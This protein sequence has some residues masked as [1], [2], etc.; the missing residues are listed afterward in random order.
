MSQYLFL[1]S[2]GPVQSFIAAARKTEDLW[3]GSYLLS[4]LAEKA[5]DEA[6][7]IPF[8]KVE[9]IYPFINTEVNKED[10]LLKQKEG[11]M[12]IA[13]LPN[14]ILLWAEVVNEEEILKFGGLLEKRVREEVKK[15]GKE[16]VEEVFK[17]HISQS[18][19]DQA[20]NQLNE[21]L[22]VYWTYL[23]LSSDYNQTRKELEKRL[24]AMKN[25]KQ[26][27][28]SEQNGLIC[29]VCGS[30]EAL[31]DG[32]I[33]EN[34]G[35]KIMR[36]KIRATWAKRA[37]EYA[38][39]SASDER[40]RIRDDERLCAVCLAK[41]YARTYFGKIRLGDKKEIPPFPS[42]TE[43]TDKKI[44]E[45]FK[46][47]A[48][49]MMD[50]DDM[51]KWISGDIY[52]EGG[53][54]ITLKYHQ[55]ISE[56]LT[57][58][59]QIYVPKYIYDGKG[60]LIYA[61]GDD[62][63]AFARLTHLYELMGSLR[64]AFQDPQKGLDEKAT[65]SMGVVIAHEKIPLQFVLNQL[66]ELEKSAKS[67]QGKNQVKKKNAFALGLYTKS[68]E[69]REVVL[70][71]SSNSEEIFRYSNKTSIPRILRN[72]QNIMVNS[73]SSTFLYHFAE[74]FLP[75][76]GSEKKNNKK[77]SHIADEAIKAELSR[78]LYR[79]R[80]EGGKPFDLEDTVN[81]LWTLYD[82][83]PSLLQFIHLLQILRFLA[84][85]QRKREEKGVRMNESAVKTG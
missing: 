61:G 33:D 13:S 8:A 2:I 17:N 70:P 76:V 64:E 74:A 83:S 71:W 51:G 3:S 10:V 73:L 46:Y 28:L 41:R 18:M 7:M 12:E 59:S 1:M 6:L 5:I 11:K 63:L 44:H 35:I 55:Q 53:K 23:L 16:A 80:K 47:Y 38:Q 34:M 4:Y 62:I 15:F 58:Y 9:L 22:E 42:V 56:K 25:E 37:K 45:D 52:Q 68:G 67:Y 57:R 69:M 54:E 20:E 27:S 43:F 78:L 84:S 77:I 79:S 21:M 60:K 65:S 36:E 39:E 50:G 66:R 30:R 72:L 26:F 85:I 40:G 29:T 24:A 19:L 75:L 48:V 49:M 32:D 82:L 31:N 14:R 81:D